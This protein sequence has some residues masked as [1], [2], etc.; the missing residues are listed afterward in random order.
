[1][2]TYI[3]IYTHILCILQGK[4]DDSNKK[5]IGS[6]FSKKKKKTVVNDDFRLKHIGLIWMYCHSDEKII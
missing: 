2:C 3:Y 5:Q 4:V 6:R 1:M